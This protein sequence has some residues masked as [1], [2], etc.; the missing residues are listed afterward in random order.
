MRSA[1][2]CSTSRRG[3]PVSTD[4]TV[5]LT[6]AQLALKL[7]TAEAVLAAGG[8]VFVGGECGRS[9]GRISD[10]CSTST[11]EFAP[12][13]VAVRIDLLGT[14]A[15]GHPHIAQAMARAQGSEI[16]MSPRPQRTDADLGDWLA[17]IACEFA[18]LTSELAQHDLATGCADMAPT[19]LHRI[20]REATQLERAVAEFRASLAGVA[21]AVPDTS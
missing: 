13:D 15:P 2:A 4:R 9:Q 14:G 11:A 5:R 7:A 6:P 20:V 18:D 10:Y 19:R 8:Q 17:R 3:V 1:P 21:A 16:A 12:L